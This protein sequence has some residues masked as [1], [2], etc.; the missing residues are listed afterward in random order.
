VIIKRQSRSIDTDRQCCGRCKGQ[1]AEIEVPKGGASKETLMKSQRT[2][3]KK[4][5]LSEYNLFMKEN[6]KIV[7]EQL[8]AERKLQGVLGTVPQAEVMKRCAQLWKER[9]ASNV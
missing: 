1:L 7:R 6:S 2:P 8:V 5:P 3:K 9:K 4:A